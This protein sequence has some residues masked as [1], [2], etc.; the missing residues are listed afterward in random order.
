MLIFLFILSLG[1]SY[2]LSALYVRYRDIRHIWEVFVQAGFWITPII[3]VSSIIPAKYSTIYFLNPLA[4][5]IT[6]SREILLEGKNILLFDMFITFILCVAIYF[7]GY[8]LY[9]YMSQSFAEE[10]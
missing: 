6:Y 8:Y 5:I 1:V 10:L 2:I 4:R 9:K 7:F 3:Y